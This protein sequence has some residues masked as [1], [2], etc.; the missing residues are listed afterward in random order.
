M[1]SVPSLT[2]CSEEVATFPG[3]WTK[4][5]SVLFMHALD[6][7]GEGMLLKF[8]FKP[9]L[10]YFNQGLYCFLYSQS[11]SL[12]CIYFVSNVRCF[13]KFLTFCPVLNQLSVNEGSSYTT[14]VNGSFFHLLCS[15]QD[16]ALNSF[17]CLNWFLTSFHMQ[18]YLFENQSNIQRQIIFVV[19]FPSEIVKPKFW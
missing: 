13:C 3:I 14:E 19:F 6:N 12:T 11:S 9:T 8:P 1:C 10:F 18:E 5:K 15:E 2:A 16:W 17:T 4:H 7:V